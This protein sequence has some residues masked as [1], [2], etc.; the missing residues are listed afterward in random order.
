MSG[1]GSAF[2]PAR[3][4]ERA[5]DVMQMFTDKKVKAII[6]L[7]GGYGSSRILDRLDYDV[8]RRNPKIL[9][10]LQRHHLAALCAAEK[11]RI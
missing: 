2:S 7:R 11:S 9:C 4:R 3:D 5:A 1:R 6:C 8:I 10:R